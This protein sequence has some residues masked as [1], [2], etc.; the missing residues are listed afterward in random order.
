MEKLSKGEEIEFQQ[1]K[2]SYD[3]IINSSFHLIPASDYYI[4]NDK[5][6]Y[7]NV[8]DDKTQ[9]NKLLENS[10]ELKIVESPA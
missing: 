6:L 3:E 4:K 2:I 10:L 8:S 7:V 5:N 9:V 1:E